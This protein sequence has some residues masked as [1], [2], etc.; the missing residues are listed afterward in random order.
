MNS[1]FALLVA[2]AVTVL[3]ECGIAALF[4]S[5]RLVYVVFLCNLLTNPVLNFALVLYFDYIGYNGY[6][7]LFACL[8]ISVLFVEAAIIKWL[9]E[10]S[11]RKATALS[12][13]FNGSSFLVALLWL[14]LHNTINAAG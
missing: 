1:L 14:V 4:K 10:Y 6:W 5:K 8:E 3:I 13:L 2:F 9:M 11:Y 7:L 12:L